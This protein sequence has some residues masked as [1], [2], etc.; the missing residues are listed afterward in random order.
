MSEKNIAG[1]AASL[2]FNI[3]GSSAAGH[4]LTKSKKKKH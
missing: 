4:V 2:S 1:I 3:M